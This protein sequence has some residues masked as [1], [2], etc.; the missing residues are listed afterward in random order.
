MASVGTYFR[1][2]RVSHIATT[3]TFNSDLI[4]RRRVNDTEGAYHHT[5]PT[6]NACRFVN[7][8]QFRF[9]VA[10]HGTIGARI[11]TGCLDTM[12]A[13]QGKLFAFYIH[14]SYRLRLFI[15]GL[16]QLL[17]NRCDLRPAPQLTLVASRAFVRI[18]LYN[19]QFLLL[20]K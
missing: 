13:L 2:N 1:T 17:C 6:R 18:Y 9:R 12:S 20:I 19:L 3:I 11:Q 7:I 15:N 5:H 4:G 14:P 16:V 10:A 8:Y